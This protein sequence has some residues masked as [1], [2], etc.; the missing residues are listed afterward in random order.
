MRQTKKENKEYNAYVE[1]RELLHQQ[2]QLLA[3]QSKGCLPMELA[4]LSAQMSAIYLALNP[5]G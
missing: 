4:E 1:E 5:C 2:L 3:E